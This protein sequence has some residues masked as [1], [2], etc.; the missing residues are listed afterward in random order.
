VIWSRRKVYWDSPHTKNK[1]KKEG[2]D[3]RK[4]RDKPEIEK[5][6]TKRVL[7]TLLTTQSQAIDKHHIKHTPIELIQ[8]SLKMHFFLTKFALAKNKLGKFYSILKP[9]VFLVLFIHNS[10][11]EILVCDTY[12][13]SLSFL[14]GLEKA[15]AAPGGAESGRGIRAPWEVARVVKVG[16]VGCTK[17]WL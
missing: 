1:I 2:F 8:K 12:P 10:K 16:L 15:C 14:W 7:K 3:Y 4:D 9:S 13:F 11:L 6:L 5:R 17:R